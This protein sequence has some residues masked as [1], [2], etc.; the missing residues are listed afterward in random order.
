MWLLKFLLVLF[1][2]WIVLSILARFALL[3][4]GKK[5]QDMFKDKTKD[6]TKTTELVKC[7]KCGVFV[8]GDEE[9]NCKE[10]DCPFKK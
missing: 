10:E 4:L 1:I 9:H 8:S 2:I 3:K 5:A 7:P 6:D